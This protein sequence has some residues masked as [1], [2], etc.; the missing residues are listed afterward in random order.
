MRGKGALHWAFGGGLRR[1]VE[2]ARFMKQGVWKAQTDQVTSIHEQ[3]QKNPWID[4]LDW[5]DVEGQSS[6]YF[7]YIITQA[8]PNVLTQEH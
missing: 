1:M 4:R 5:V 7:T 2:I 6:I 3:C 8:P